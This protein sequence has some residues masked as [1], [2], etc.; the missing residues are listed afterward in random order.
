MRVGD[1]REIAP[2]S[3]GRDARP[4]FRGPFAGSA[5]RSGAHSRYPSLPMTTTATPRVA[6]GLE[7]LAVKTIQF[8][9]VDA[10]EKA[11]SGHPGTPMGAA[12]MAFVL[13][14]EYLRFDPKDPKWPARDRFVLSC[15]HAC[16]L[17]YALLHLYGFD[18]P[19]EEIQKFRQWESHTP[20]HPEPVETPG[21]EI[22]TGP[23]GQGV[24][25][26][27]GMAIA[28]RMLA[29]RF[30]TP[31]FQP[32]PQRVWAIVSDGDLMEGIAAEAASLGGHLGLSNLTF[33]YDDNKITIEGATD[34]A[35]SEDVGKRFE[36]YG[37][38]VQRIDGHDRAAIRRAIDAALGVKDRPQMI[39]CR[40]TIARGAPTKA[41]TAKAHGEPL[42]AEEVAATKKALGW[43]SEP[44]FHVPDEVKAFFAKRTA[45]LGKAR[46]AWAEAEKTWRAAH[47]DLAAQWDALAGRTTPADLEAQCLAGVPAKAD[48]TR[49]LSNAVL[50]KAAACVPAL[51][52]GSADLEPSTKTAI[53]GS[54]SI[55][56]GEFAGRNFH[57]GIREHAMGAV[58]NGMAAH[59]GFIPYGAT[60]L[61]FSDYM[62]PSIRLAAL[63]G[64]QAIYVFTHDSVFLGEDGPTHQPIE[65]VASLRLIP[66]L[67]TWR[68]ADGVETA[69]A[70]A[71]AL[72]RQDGP[73]ALVLTRQKVPV[74]ARASALDAKSFG[75]GGYVLADATGGKPKVVFLATGSEVGLAVEA[76]AVLDAKGIATRVVSVPS[77]ETFERQDASYRDAC[78]P[79]D[80]RA[81]AIEAGVPDPWHRH[82]GRDG[83]VIGIRRFG[84]SAPA[85]VIAEKFGFTAPQVTAAVEK[86]LR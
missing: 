83:L 16:M 27:V 47:A 58:M 76:K 28:A 1:G 23:L 11:K 32:F 75:R 7:D 86:L 30:G 45:E 21:V 43:P 38:H 5:H 33:L 6:P 13:W 55:R 15:G 3:Q 57:F 73:S 44:A 26:A 10:V 4:T 24:G 69:L 40:T 85:E 66:N 63:M 50:Q 74:L 72:R 51:A 78:V 49:N 9:A 70:W 12:D 46:A 35:F 22:A 77:L 68:P 64:L 25:N 18:L 41:G 8:L 82:V 67:V 71:A 81:V 62:R 39:V 42:G 48:A 61:T 37:W 59:G 14:H 2:L 60:F 52:G 65:H 19:M 53:K 31:E 34:L 56:R 36:A 20:G 17:Q 54:P 80:A 29:A 84:A 79:R